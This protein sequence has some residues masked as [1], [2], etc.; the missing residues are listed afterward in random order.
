MY[1]RQRASGRA[2][3]RRL[4]GS[5][6]PGELLHARRHR[7]EERAIRRD[8]VQM[9]RRVRGA[10]CQHRPRATACR[11]RTATVALSRRRVSR[12]RGSSRA[13]SRSST[14]CFWG[15]RTRA[16]SARSSR[17]ARRLR[18]GLDGVLHRPP[19]SRPG[20][21]GGGSDMPSASSRSG[22]AHFRRTSVPVRTGT[23]QRS[24]SDYR[25]RSHHRRTSARSERIPLRAGP[26]A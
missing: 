26:Q 1:R 10:V 16:P 18:G 7:R 21:W 5:S 19:R 9:V 8:L 14:S 17:A 23:N 15:T 20:H 24:A 2:R 4:K 12:Y 3:A 11:R 22:R 6:R 25:R 13:T